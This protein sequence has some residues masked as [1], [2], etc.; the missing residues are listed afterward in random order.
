MLG[1]VV[2]HAAERFGERAA[3]RHADGRELSFAGLDRLADRCAGRLG[4]LGVGDGS[5]IV[6]R[7]ASDIPYVV[8]YAAAARI[9][10][11]TA[12]INPSLSTVE[13]DCLAELAQPDLVIDDSNVD[14]L[15]DD[16]AAPPPVEVEPDGERV[17]AIVFTSG[18]TGRPKA[19]V[20][21]ERHI[22]AIAA[23]DTGD[24][25]VVGSASSDVGAR[26]L[27]SSTQFAHVGFMTKLAWYLR[28]GTTVHLL[29]RWSADEVLRT[30]A[31]HRIGVI[32]AVAPQVALL[33]RSGL[34]D[35]L[36][37][38]CVHTLI[39][40]GA[41][42]PPGLIRDATAAFDATYSVRYSSTES[43][44]VG[45]AVDFRPGDDP[46]DSIGVPRPGVEARVVDG[47]LQLRS[48][49]VFDGYFADAEATVA[50]FDD[51]W[52]RTG[53]GA[54]VAV[55][56]TYRLTGRLGDMYI[57]GGYNV[58]PSEVEAVLSQHPAV[59]SVAVVA[60]PDDVMGEK[61][62]ACVVARTAGLT[63]AE[64]CAFAADRLAR[65]KLPE[66]LVL[67]DDLPLTPMQKVDRRE[68]QRLVRSLAAE[69][70]E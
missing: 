27:L 2:R 41:A 64:L 28:S 4:A 61:G 59:D 66:R 9:G 21:R 46:S 56:G 70:A 39:V 5:R 63:L 57:R 22:A 33:L 62:A 54:T 19:A 43:G 6:L 1:P 8:C 53:D 3:V 25:G 29:P 37:L 44:G 30:V 47:E 49:A 68:L 11:A 45:L 35:Q 51:G 58:H 17:A 65:W 67:L 40:G 12:G 34:R 13:G 42:S 23:I 24:D 38:S 50:A 10:A 55:D 36:D 26:D 16:G 7:L 69:R 48:P 14:A 60:Y 31:Q 18:T 15:I 32:G 20:F 52:L